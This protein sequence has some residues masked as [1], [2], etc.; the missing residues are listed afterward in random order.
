MAALRQA[1][2]EPAFAAAWADGEASPLAAATAE[3]LAVLDRIDSGQRP[4]GS[5]SAEP[6]ALTIREREVL[7]L[8]VDG[9]SDKEIAAALGITRHTASHY[10]RV[11]R[12]KLGAPSR[13]AAAAL[14]IRA[15]LL[16]S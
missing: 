9:L 2:G 1:L 6:D 12:G 13:A 8:L 4:S 14:A 11:I 5:L 3:A 16:S 10:V 15:G 7:R